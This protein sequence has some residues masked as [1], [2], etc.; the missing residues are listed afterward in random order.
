MG[1]DLENQ[2][3][4]SAISS[5]VADYWVAEHR[6][7][8]LSQ[9]P[10]RLRQHSVEY[11]R[12]Q[13]HPGKTLKLFI[14][15]N[16]SGQVRTVQHPTHHEVVGLVPAHVSDAS[17][18]L[19]KNS[20]EVSGSLQ[21]EPRYYKPIFSAF[22]KPLTKSKRALEIA[23]SDSQFHELDQGDDVPADWYEVEHE[24]VRKPG[25]AISDIEV[26]ARLRRWAEEKKIPHASLIEQVK[27]MRA[28]DSS[29]ALARVFQAMSIS[30]QQRIMIPLDV[31]IKIVSRS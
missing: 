14:E 16:L 6:P 8:L 19:F 25:E 22:S 30:D 21:Q 24:F 7:L 31:V 2:G 3:I 27:K 28:K 4:V 10:G 23:G 1:E 13:L 11:V 12:E 18:L 15:E 5:I 20:E 17:T 26:G 9:L 29:A